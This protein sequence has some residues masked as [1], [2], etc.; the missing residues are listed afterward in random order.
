MTREN[1]QFQCRLQNK[2]K[3]KY[4]WKTMKKIWV[5]GAFVADCCANKSL[6]CKWV[7]IHFFPQFFL[8]NR[9]FKILH[10]TPQKQWVRFIYFNSNMGWFCELLSRETLIFELKQIN[11]TGTHF[12]CRE[13]SPTLIFAFF[14]VIL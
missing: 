14:H 10:W 6:S 1:T 11:I 4:I 2:T 3:S 13:G 7:G 5:L 8:V 9:W 12:F